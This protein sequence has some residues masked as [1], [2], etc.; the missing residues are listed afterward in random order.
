MVY[1]PSCF[2]R[3]PESITVITRLT[4]PNVRTSRYESHA[5]I[6]TVISLTHVDLY[7]YC[8]AT[9]ADNARAGERRRGLIGQSAVRAVMVVI[10]PPTRR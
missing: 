2:G 8:S 7:T 1:A 10:H 5:I 9:E 6:D 3:R 4:G